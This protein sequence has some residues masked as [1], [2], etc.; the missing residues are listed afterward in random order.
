MTAS[1]F[2]GSPLWKAIPRRILNTHSVGDFTSHDSATLGTRRPPG[3]RAIRVS[4]MLTQRLFSSLSRTPRA[5]SIRPMSWVWQT[6][7]DSGVW[8]TV[9]ATAAVTRAPPPRSPI[10]TMRLVRDLIDTALLA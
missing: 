2:S 5:G 3:S 7:T 6:V 10:S 8:A 1:A 4:Y 9:G